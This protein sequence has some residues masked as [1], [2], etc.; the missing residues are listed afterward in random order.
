MYQIIG[1]KNLG[2]G[3]NL[4]N[5][6]APDVAL[7]A[8][9]GQFIILRVNKNGE[10]I[11][12]TI[13]NSDKNDKTI[14]ILVQTLGKTTHLLSELNVGESLADLVGPLGVPTEIKKFGTVVC[15]GGGFGTAAIYPIAKAMKAEGNRVISIIGAR[16]K[17]LLLMEDE[18]KAASSEVLAATNDGSYGTKGIVTDVLRNLIY[19]KKIQIDR[20]IAIGPVIMMKAVSDL[21]KEKSIK[22]IVSLNPIMIDGTGM[23]GACRVLVGNK[24]KFACVDGPDFDGHLVDFDNLMSRLKFYKE[25]EKTSYDCHMKAHHNLTS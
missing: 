15:I 23:C 14:T 20:V 24:T 22:T 18:M 13:A 5:I 2:E 8:L 16:S 11:P 25:E 1:K 21:T 10:R 9:P 3:I 19:D 12:I 4:Y 7:K 6:S 17:E